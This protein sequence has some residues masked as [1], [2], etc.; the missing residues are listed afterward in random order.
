MLLPYKELLKESA[1]TTGGGQRY[2]VSVMHNVC[3][4]MSRNFVIPQ[5]PRRLF[6]LGLRYATV[7]T[8]CYVELLVAYCNTLVAVCLKHWLAKTGLGP[9][10][11]SQTFILFFVFFFPFSCIFYIIIIIIISKD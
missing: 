9:M 2:S 7:S 10:C 1:I 8:N 11:G 6:G 5:K 4:A 3:K